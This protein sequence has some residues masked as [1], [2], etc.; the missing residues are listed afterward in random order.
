MA[1]PITP[2]AR[3]NADVEEL[4]PIADFGDVPGDLRG[5]LLARLAMRRQARAD[6]VARIARD[7]E[8]VVELTGGGRDAVA[9][10]L[11]G[12][13]QPRAH[14]IDGRGQFVVQR[15]RDLRDLCQRRFMRA[16]HLRRYGEQVGF[17]LP[18]PRFERSD[19][20]VQRRRRR[21]A[22]LR[23]LDRFLGER[24]ELRL[25]ARALLVRDEARLAEIAREPLR[26]IVD[27]RQAGEQTVHPLHRDIARPCELVVSVGDHRG[28]GGELV[29][30]FGQPRDGIESELLDGRRLFGK[31]ALCIGKMEPERVHRLVERRIL[32]A[33]RGRDARETCLF[34]SARPQQCH[35]QHR[36]QGQRH[37]DSGDQ[38]RPFGHRR[39]AREA[40]GCRRSGENGPDEA[41]QDQ[42]GGGD[43]VAPD[44][45]TCRRVL[46]VR[47]AGERR[48]VEPVAFG[49]RGRLCLG[50]DRARCHRLR[51]LAV[52]IRIC[53]GFPPQTDD[54][55][56]P[57]HSRILAANARHE[58][59]T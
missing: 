26:D 54:F 55:F 51:R 13:A 40:V 36:E 6:S 35:P 57:R 47:F 56:I 49:G 58:T 59:E 21:F 32:V 43:A 48:H 8:P 33:Q 10:L 53:R 11:P 44:R 22:G 17:G 42:Q 3:R 14:R 30:A 23:G 7:R 28:I 19:R 37:R 41:E 27:A 50:H 12:L 52:R 4:Q 29:A 9:E 25:E 15:G 24:G 31:L 45:R 2:G 34:G 1:R 16:G 18:G 46:D 39:R 5:Q 38:R 20:I